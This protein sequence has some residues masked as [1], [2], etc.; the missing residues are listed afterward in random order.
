MVIIYINVNINNN[1]SVECMK[2]IQNWIQ[3]KKILV[4]GF[5][6]NHII[7]WILIGLCFYKKK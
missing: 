5:H 1:Q 3:L 7:K 4:F 6:Y 2:K